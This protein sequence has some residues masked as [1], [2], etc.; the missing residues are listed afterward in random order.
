MR[1]HNSIKLIQTA[2]VAV[3]HRANTA[4]SLFLRVRLNSFLG[5]VLCVAMITTVPHERRAEIVLLLLINL[6]RHR[7]ALT[8]RRLD[9]STSR[10]RNFYTD[11]PVTGLL[12]RTL[13]LAVG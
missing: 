4:I 13:R 1:Y 2:F 11:G 8:W 9:K 12:M 6:R 3:Q 7:A 10:S 5:H